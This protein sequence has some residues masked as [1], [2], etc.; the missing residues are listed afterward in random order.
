MNEV[1]AA[2]CGTVRR[3]VF[4]VEVRFLCLQFF[5]G[6]LDGAVQ[7]RY[8]VITGGIEET[9]GIVGA[10]FRVHGQFVELTEH[11]AGEGVG[12]DLVP[13]EGGRFGGEG[14]SVFFPLAA[15][16][17][18]PFVARLDPELGSIA[19]GKYSFH[20]QVFGIDVGE[21]QRIA[22]LD[23]FM[24]HLTGGKAQCFH[25]VIHCGLGN[26]GGLPADTD[27]ESAVKAGGQIGGDLNHRHFRTVTPQDEIGVIGAVCSGEAEH[28]LPHAGQAAA[29]GKA[30]QIYVCQTGHDIIHGLPN[31]I[32]I[33]VGQDRAIRQ[34]G[35][36]EIA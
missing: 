27:L 36:K 6:L 4:R 17:V 11:L 19:S 23:H 5:L 26:Y 32:R 9:G 30:I 7:G 21:G 12:G 25:Q 18:P 20:S 14:R 35:R 33:A 13:I 16:P 24:V 34:C 10:V 8:H 29:H 28:T 1:G 2:L 15:A 22:A 3:A 31:S